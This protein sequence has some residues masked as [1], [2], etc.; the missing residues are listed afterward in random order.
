MEQ[1]KLVLEVLEGMDVA[2]VEVVLLTPLV[3]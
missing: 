3:V 2:A 1:V